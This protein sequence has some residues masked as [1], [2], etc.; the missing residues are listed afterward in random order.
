MEITY[1][2]GVV[3]CAETKCRIETTALGPNTIR[4]VLRKAR[5]Q[6]PSDKPGIIFVKFPQQWFEDGKREATQRQLLADVG[7]FFGGANESPRNQRIVSVKFYTEVLVYRDGVVENTIER[8]ETSH[9]RNKFY[10]NR[11]WDFP[12]YQSPPGET[13][14]MPSAWVRLINFP[15]EL[16]HHAEAE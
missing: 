2:D 14:E 11:D 5:S 16:R 1:P 12:L 7:K 8:I 10:P 13:I 15:S 6:L 4:N 3:V 9:H